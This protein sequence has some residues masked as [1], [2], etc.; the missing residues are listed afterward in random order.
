MAIAALSGGDYDE[1]GMKGVGIE[2]AFMLVSLL[3]E[4]KE[5][6]KGIIEDLRAKLQERPDDDLAALS[7]KGC[8]GCKICG[9]G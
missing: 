5:D 3:L 2:K 8:T 9:G 6:D 1:S 7:A 4:G